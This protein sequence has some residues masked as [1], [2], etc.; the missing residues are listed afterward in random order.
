MSIGKSASASGGAQE[1][2][3]IEAVQERI[4]RRIKE[5]KSFNVAGIQDRWDQRLENT[6]KAVNKLVAEA[7]GSGGELYKQ[8][9]IPPLG[10]ALDQTFGD[11]YT[12]DEFH[13]E[14]RK[15]L[16]QAG[17]RLA[18]VSALLADRLANPGKPAKQHAPAP[19]PAPAPVAAAAEP[20]PP[21]PQIGRAHV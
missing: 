15:A 10:A 16:D 19:A 11:R 2:A 21:P 20:P 8:Y 3:E 13:D 6:Q 5:L 4:A 18:A 7:V 17:K 1:R 14:V 9:A 12:Q